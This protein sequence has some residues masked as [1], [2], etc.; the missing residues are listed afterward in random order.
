MESSLSP[1][2]SDIDAPLQVRV[3]HSLGACLF[4][5]RAWTPVPLALAVLFYARG[6]T[7][8]WSSVLGLSLILC[9]ELTRIWAVRHIGPISRTRRAHVGPLVTTGPYA[10]TRNPLY[11]GNG[12]LWTGFVIAS[13][14][15][16]MLPFAWM[17]F[18]VQQSAIVAWEESQLL[19]CYPIEYRHYAERVPRW[20]PTGPGRRQTVVRWSWSCVLLSERGT[21]LAILIMTMALAGRRL[22][23]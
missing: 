14:V 19:A 3:A 15:S 8:L 12:L 7:G 10:R 4:R 5:H 17:V 16:W 13:G 22:L 2:P 6:T 18:A 20:R 11:V 21:L 1:S 23:G 9:G